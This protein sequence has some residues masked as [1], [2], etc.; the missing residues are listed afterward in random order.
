[1]N[2]SVQANSVAVN[3]GAFISG[4]DTEFDFAG[5]DR[6]YNSMIVDIG[7]YE[8]QAPRLFADAGVDMSE[9][10]STQFLP[11]AEVYPY[12]KEWTI[13][14]NDDVYISYEESMEVLNN[15]P[16]QIPV[17]IELSVTNGFITEK[18]T[19]IITN[20]QP[21]AY[22][23]EDILLINPI[24]TN[25]DYAD[26]NFNAN[27]PDN[28]NETGKW[29]QLSTGG[30]TI[31]DDNIYNPTISDIGYGQHLFEWKVTNIQDITC[32]NSDSLLIVAGHSYTSI[33][34]GI[35]NWNTP[36]DWAEGDLPGAADSVTIY[37]VEGNVNIGNAICDRLY[38]GN[39]GTLNITGT[40]KT[41]SNLSCRT[42]TVEENAKKFDG[43]KGVA[44]LYIKDYAT[45]NVGS[46][47]ISKARSSSGS[48]LF[49]GS[50]GTVF[51]RPNAEKG[52]GTKA[53]SGLNIGSGGFIFIRPNAEKGSKASAGLNIGSGGFVF[54]R[55][56]AEKNNAE[57]SNLLG[58]IVVGAGGSLNLEQTIAGTP[59]GYLELG[60]GRT[61]HL[62]P[63]TS[64]AAGGNFGIYGGTVFIRPN[65]E[66]NTKGFASS[67]IYC[68]AGGTIFIRPNAEKASTISKLITPSI[69]IDGGK[70]V[71]GNNVKSKAVSGSLRFNQIFI[72]P[73]AE[74]GL[75]TDTALIVYP[76]GE[77]A[78]SDSSYW[79]QSSISVGSG[80]AISFFEGSIINLTNL[81]FNYSYFDLKKEAS[82][83][84]MN[85]VANYDINFE[86]TF[87]GGKRNLFSPSVETMNVWDF[88]DNK[89][90]GSWNETT[91]SWTL[92]G[93]ADIL[94][95]GNGYFVTYDLTDTYKQFYGS[96]N[97]GE[98]N[99]PVT[100]TDIGN[101]E[102][103][104]WNLI[105]NPYP[106]AIDLEQIDLPVDFYNSFY[107]YDP[108]NKQFMLYQQGGVSLN[109]A[110]QYVNPNLAFFI[111]TDANS[112]FNIDNDARV[113]YMNTAKNTKEISNILKLKA[114]GLVYSDETAVLFN[115]DATDNFDKEYD[116][117]K[118]FAITVTSPTLYTKITGKD[119]P[120]AINTLEYQVNTRT[121]PLYFEAPNTGSYTI[122]VTELTFDPSVTVFLKDLS[123][124][125]MH[126]LKTNPSY[127]FIYTNGDDPNRFEIIFDGFVGVEDIAN[128]NSINIFSSKNT[129]FINNKYDNSKVEVYDLNGKLL[130][131]KNIFNSGINSL[132]VNL[133]QSIYLV[134]LISQEETICKKV[135]ISK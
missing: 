57:K 9:C 111:K 70:V 21:I 32:F 16:P 129:I 3:G 64:K 103:E 77:L 121:I 89:T 53:S 24:I 33:P 46:E 67:G 27:I 25:N 26:V 12:T 50:G 36:S 79:D 88:G 15:L 76:S 35:F 105:G 108:S 85:Q 40:S 47:Y 118:M 48:G 84:D 100:L 62:S 106:S 45:L 10:N 87:E 90:I 124:N 78:L 30:L 43:I 65:A 34:D 11:Y 96:A 51:I 122:D 119:A 114:S 54:I 81:N 104:G 22:A 37:G 38:I 82:L 134:K 130:F 63:S 56:N 75:A 69:I 71:V 107:T 101:F 113:H 93:D 115:N 126:D 110:N 116:A 68:G 44:N 8:L 127:N 1:M 86:Q 80:E 135:V 60:S 2:F 4:Q 23:G 61:I 19:I 73:N 31:S 41:S 91:A 13:L 112:I 92:L 52:Y 132:N 20:T 39:G 28:I 29:T 123:D 120:I 18:D 66:K 55:P 42:I 6:I 72:R 5:N 74:K 49:I 133:P 83:I 102:F 59:G 14:N 125:S 95:A 17:E 117:A 131:Q 128:E 7:A 98:F 109:G 94:N 97:S 99:I 58:D